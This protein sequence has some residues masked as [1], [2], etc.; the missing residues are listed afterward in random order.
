MVKLGSKQVKLRKQGWLERNWVLRPQ[1]KL[2]R[3]ECRALKWE[4][5]GLNKL[6][7][8]ECKERRPLRNWVCRQVKL[9]CRRANR[10]RALVKTSGN[11]E[12][13]TASLVL[14]AQDNLEQ[15]LGN[16]ASW[17]KAWVSWVRVL[18]LWV[19]SRRV[20]VK[21]IRV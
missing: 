9:E 16:T 10:L 21:P 11:L 20:W 18:D 13:N 19:C 12:H 5:K 6:G 1:V 17:V 8:W 2:G 15:L 4:C 7:R 3:W 14:L